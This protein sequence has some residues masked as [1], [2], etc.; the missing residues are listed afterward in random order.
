MNKTALGIVAVAALIGTPALSAD[1]PVKAPAAEASSWTGFYVGLGVGFGWTD[2]TSVPFTPASNIA[3]AVVLGA[4]TESAVA[5]TTASP[6]SFN[7]KG[8]FGGVD[9]GYN[10]QVNRNWLIGLEADINTSDING[11]GTSQFLAGGAATG[12]GTQDSVSITANRNILWFGTVRPRVG[13]LANDNLLIYATGGLA[14]GRISENVTHQGFNAGIGYGA[15]HSSIDCFAAVP[16]FI[17]VSTRTTTGWTGGGGAEYRLP[18]TNVSIRA[19]Y[20]YVNLGG[21]HVMNL[22]NAPVAGFTPA[23]FTAAF[24][25]TAFQSVKLGLN[26]K[27]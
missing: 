26:L 12:L 8:A 23:S 18:G 11:G 16:C 25:G 17:G 20:L 19:E 14:Y 2:T 21:D 4:T 10:L 13:W 6:A 22:V 7:T 5:P 1:M 27:L 24:T 15:D 3:S 9:A